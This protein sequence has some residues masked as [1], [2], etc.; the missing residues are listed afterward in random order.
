MRLGAL[1]AGKG[2]YSEAEPVMRKM[3]E[4]EERLS[5]GKQYESAIG[6]HNLGTSLRLMRRLDEAEPLLRRSMDLFAQG[7]ERHPEATKPINT[8]ALLLMERHQWAEAEELLQKALAL[9][10]ESY[11][12]SHPAIAMDLRHLALLLSSTGRAHEAEPV[13][14][15]SLQISQEVNGATHLKTART[16][17]VLASIL[18]DLGRTEEAEPLARQVLEIFEQVLGPDHPLT[19]TARKDL[20]SLTV[21]PSPGKLLT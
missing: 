6:L 3:L 1:L 8:L 14:R 2:L 13:I 19:Q 21:A 7:Q 5:G 18:H 12:R 11:G 16:I 17:R 20:S 9:D 10:Q 15:R 4:I